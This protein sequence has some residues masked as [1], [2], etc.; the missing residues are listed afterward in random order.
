MS[1]SI[2]SL[3][4][5]TRQFGE[6][7]AVENVSFSLETGAIFGLLGP[8]GSGKSTLIR[9]M[10]GVLPPTSGDVYLF[11]HNVWKNPERIKE[12]IGYMSQAF[13][14]YGD[15][16][17]EE[18]CRFYA[19]IYGIEAGTQNQRIEDILNLTHLSN[20]HRQLAQTLSGGWKQR[21]AL[22]CSLLHDPQIL[23]LD[24]PTAGIDPVARRELWDL[25]FELSTQGKTLFVSTHYM[26][27][28]ER[29]SKIGYLQNAKL[30]AFGDPKTLK[31]RPEV[32]PIGM[33]RYEIS[34]PDAPAA[35]LALRHQEGV[36]E[37]T[38][39]RGSLQVLAAESITQDEFSQRLGVPRGELHLKEAQPSLED[40]FVSLTRENHDYGSYNDD[41]LPAPTEEPEITNT[42]VQRT[43]L[44]SFRGFT[45][46]LLKE[47]S[48][49]LR[50]PST[51]FFMFLVPLLQLTIFGYAIDT[52]IEHIPTVVLNLDNREA[53]RELIAAF[54]NTRTF[55]IAKRVTQ[56]KAFDEL[57]RS[58]TA[59]VGI[60]VPADYS[61][62]LLRRTQPVV[63]ILIDGSDSQVANAALTASKLLGLT[64]SIRIAKQLGEQMQIAPARDLF[65]DAALPIEV[66]PRILYNPALESAH[67]FVPGLIC[68]ILQ[69]VMLFLTAFAIVRERE[70]GTLEQ[71]FVTPVGR[72]GLLLGKLVPYLAAGAV[73]LAVVLAAMIFLFG[74]PIQGSLFLLTALSLLF[75]LCSLGLGILVSTLART[76]LE[77]M[78]FA[79]IIMLPSVLL[80]GFIFPRSQMPLP[81]YGLTF[82]IPATYFLEIIRG[83]VLRGASLPD[84]R[85]PFVGLCICTLIILALS[86]FRFRK[87]LE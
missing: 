37:A 1:S 11:G 76:Q 81:I 68:L 47:F 20:R 14:L 79:F 48:H 41:K 74:V 27:E 64:T 16:T 25:L 35:L 18:N 30:I 57:L 10:C 9:M 49:I 87:R 38:L 28:A 73:E 45:A 51:L 46:V 71:L 59:K 2:V 85:D 34:V 61:E 15:L 26:D 39:Y 63:Q 86:I 54:E 5:L 31:A 22:A 53:S 83:I 58:G 75:I 66:R 65:G 33:K 32:T 40:V 67:F 36:Q 12:S 19:R 13:S 24:E 42:E 69:L 62:K 21:L 72:V 7:T 23:F 55:A 8:N 44:L 4:H 60:R 3:R 17:V 78:Q 82:A 70:H 29:C 52:E 6:I 56:Q 43:R 80:S 84:L 77:A 50:E